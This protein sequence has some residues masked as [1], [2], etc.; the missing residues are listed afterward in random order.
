MSR[1]HERRRRP[2]LFMLVAMLVALVATACGSDADESSTTAAGGGETTT[3]ASGGGG[4]CGDITINENSWVG[5]SANVYVAKH[6]LENTYDCT[7][8]VTKIAEIPAFQAMADG[9]VDVVLEDW[10]HT[11]EYAKYI[12]EQKKVQDAGSLGVTGHIGWYVPTYVVEE[13]PELATWEGLKTKAS[14]FKTPESGDKGQLLDGDP[15]YVTNDE[16][17]V[18]N[19]GLDLKVVFAG[20]EASQIT[21]VQQA[22]AKKEPILFYWYTPQ[23]L[24][25]EL[26]LTEVT[27]PAR[28]DGCD[29]DPKKVACA[30]PDYDLRKLMSTEFAESGSPA[31]DF[32]KKFSWA[33]EDQN[34]VAVSI[35][36]EKMKPEDAAAAWVEANPDKV[37]A[38]TGGA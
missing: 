18:E 28:T 12:E 19:L 20:G 31:V 1:G 24:N 13:H 35:A 32:V 14:L 37:E 29:A 3:A 33:N 7:V 34:T 26:D 6:I 23:W 22:Y 30:Y 17:L 10:Q 21:S 38:W 25:A 16:A 2:W 36:G 15:S 27:L 11:T 4:D 8:K 9:K 5:S